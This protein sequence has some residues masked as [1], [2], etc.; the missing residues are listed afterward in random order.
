M[1]GNYGTVQTTGEGAGNHEGYSING[2]WVFMSGD[3]NSCGIYNDTDNKWAVL[4]YRNAQVRLDYNGNE[5]LK[6][7]GG[8]VT[9]TGEINASAFS[10]RGTG[11]FGYNFD[12]VF[13]RP[14]GQVYISVDD[15]FYFRD[16]ANYFGI[17]LNGN[18]T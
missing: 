17:K 13:M 9:V 1:S 18:T 6:T 8:G 14:D 7:E 4:C 16:N 15:N 12:G 5:K 3:A 11:S 2:R 10:T